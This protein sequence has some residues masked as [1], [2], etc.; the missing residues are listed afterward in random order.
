MMSRASRHQR[1]EM[2]QTRISADAIMYLEHHFLTD[3]RCA[4]DLKG[5]KRPGGRTYEGHS[6]PC[7][8]L[9]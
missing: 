2:V 6:I 4:P 1:P 3:V 9:S 5:S 8:K 7:P